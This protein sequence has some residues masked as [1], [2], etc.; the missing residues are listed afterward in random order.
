MKTSRVMRTVF[1]S[2]VLGSV[3]PA[4]AQSSTGSI[5]G[6]VTDQNHAVVVGATV[7]AK[8][9]ATGFVRSVV[10]NSSRTYRLTDIP[11]G[12]YEIAV[13]AAGF[14][15]FARTGI[16]LDVG[17]IAKV[18][19]VLQPG[20]ITQTVTVTENASMMNTN[21]AEVRNRF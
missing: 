20:G 15:P 8:N 16:T 10:T 9:T 4:F 2:I 6:T 19:A 11:S 13:E 1:L 17:Q 7:F 3:G 5:S 12:E 18:D 21:S 14:K